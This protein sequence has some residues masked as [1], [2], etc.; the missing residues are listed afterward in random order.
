MRT[1]LERRKQT[2]DR[3]ELE[4]GDAVGGPPFACDLYP[5]RRLTAVRSE[6][7]H[8]GEFRRDALIDRLDGSRRRFERDGPLERFAQSLQPLIV[9][10]QYGDTIGAR[11]LA[12]EHP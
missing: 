3:C 2:L 5:Q 7:R 4:A 11:A 12:V 10:A 9:M 1:W 6:L 8:C